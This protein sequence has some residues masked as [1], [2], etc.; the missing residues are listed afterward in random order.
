MSRAGLEARLGQSLYFDVG[1]G[2]IT[3]HVKRSDTHMHLLEHV[4]L[5]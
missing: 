2:W 4:V 1:F 3:D 5:H